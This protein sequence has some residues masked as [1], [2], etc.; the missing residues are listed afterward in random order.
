M[1]DHSIRTYPFYWKTVQLSSRIPETC[2]YERSLGTSYW[3]QRARKA[4]YLYSET[5][6]YIRSRKD[7]KEPIWKTGEKQE[8]TKLHNQ[9]TDWVVTWGEKPN[10]V[11]PAWKSKR[12]EPRSNDR[13]CRT[14]ICRQYISESLIPTH[15]INH[16]IMGSPRSC[17]RGHH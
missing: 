10:A 17:D 13:L 1:I 12:L 2:V 8:R 6:T 4:Y 11:S 14:L 9:S 3:S 7:N 16:S 5:A 15:L